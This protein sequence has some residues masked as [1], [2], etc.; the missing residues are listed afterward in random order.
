MSLT[1]AAWGAIT[2][3]MVARLVWALAGPDLVM[4]DAAGYRELARALASGHGY[5]LASGLSAYWMPGWPAWMS[6]AYRIASSDLTVVLGNVVLGGVT[7]FA[8]WVLA[9]ELWDERQAWAAAAVCAL[10]PSLVLLP[11]LLLSENLAIPLFVLAVV[12]LVRALRSERV[13]DWV[14]FGI[15]AALLTY[16][17]EACGAIVLAGFLLGPRRRLARALVA[18][19]VVLVL[20][21]PWVGRNRSVLGTPTLTTSAG[22]NLCIGLGQG[23]TGGHRKLAIDD[24]GEMDRHRDGLV[25]AKRG[26]TDA[27]WEIITLLPA[28][29]SRLFV[30]DDWIA[31]DFLSRAGA[32]AAWVR[33]LE[34]LCDGAYWGL[35]IATL[36][37][38][39]RGTD[40]RLLGAAVATLALPIVAT[41]GAGR[42]HAPL[43]PLLCIFASR[44]IVDACNPGR[45]PKASQSSSSSAAERWAST[46]TSSGAP[47]TSTRAPRVT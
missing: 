4:L 21:A 14:V 34:V 27:P 25:C 15:T 11:R 31:D 42:F 28:K 19:A 35:W 3:G 40:V 1:R 39:R 6:V 44:V 12:A 38:W 29:L 9:R 26:L 33:V 41:F 7:V 32:S 37:A 36:L 23:A 17:R 8:T 18:C 16:V 13:L 46:P 30:W 5:S 47:P 45:P 2:L 20:V 10:V 22:V 24:E 43:L